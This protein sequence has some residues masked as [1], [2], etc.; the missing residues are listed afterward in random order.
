MKI[1]GKEALSALD[2]AQKTF[3]ELFQHGTLSVEMYRPQGTDLQTPH[4][5][6][7]VYVV[8]SGTGQFECKGKVTAFGP[9]D[10]LFVP[11]FAPHR[12]VQ[13]TDDFAT[14]VFFYGPKGGE[15]NLPVEIRHWNPAFSEAFFRLNKQWIEVDYDLEPLD[16]AVLSNRGAS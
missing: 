2:G 7:E 9:G 1:T 11:A 13:F 14:W 6:D 15:A 8:F 3:I 10:F 5:R 4:D 16:I 12:F